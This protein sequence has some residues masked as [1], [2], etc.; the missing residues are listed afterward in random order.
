IPL[1][2]ISNLDFRIDYNAEVNRLYIPLSY[3]GYIYKENKTKQKDFYA[4]KMIPDVVRAFSTVFMKSGSTTSGGA[5]GPT[6]VTNFKNIQECVYNYFGK[7]HVPVD[8][9]RLQDT[10]A[11]VLDKLIAE[12][13]MLPPT[14][15]MF[16]EVRNKA[17]ADGAGFTERGFTPL[18]SPHIFNY[19]IVETECAQHSRDAATEVSL[20]QAGVPAFVRINKALAVW[21]NFATTFGCNNKQPMNAPSNLTCSLF[22]ASSAGR[23]FA[24]I[25]FDD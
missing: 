19:L 14:Y 9:K 23:R 25:L 18:L 12:L 11:G 3:F 20:L 16:E 24:S 8:I 21:S 2:L 15:E 22:A 5:W 13:M 6:T 10:S 4:I 1:P 17:N 7:E